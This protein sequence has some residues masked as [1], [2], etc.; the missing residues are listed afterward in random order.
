M[1][2]R[3]PLTPDERLARVRENVLRFKGPRL[4]KPKPLRP[5][6]LIICGFGPSLADTWPLIRDPM[7]KPVVMTTSGAHDYLIERGI[8]PDYHVEIDPREHKCFFI[9]NSH[10]DVTYLLAST[11]HPKMFEMLRGRKVTMWH[12]FTDDDLPR[13]VAQLEKLEPGAVSLSGGTNA[14]MRAIV[15]GR[16]VGHARM[17]GHGLDCCYLG[18]RQ[19]A[20]A[21]SGARHRTVRIECDGR[22][23]E[24]S[25]V[26]M[27][28]TDDFFN[29]LRGLGRVEISIE[30]DGLLAARLALHR[31]NPALALSPQW[32]RPLNFT[33]RAA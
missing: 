32:W 3:L 5:E 10:P 8:I 27:Q 12:S 6:R 13:Q 9:R 14:G 21:H 19:W 31:R 23:F 29:Q 26:M 15:V 2:L 33:L 16:H 24:T 18:S 17:S 22:A 7:D 11:V 1:E 25:D 28:A 4:R 20:G 30:G